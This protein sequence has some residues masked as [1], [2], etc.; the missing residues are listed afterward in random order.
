ME[1]TLIER[2]IE[3]AK[4]RQYKLSSDL[5]RNISEKH[6]TKAEKQREVAEV[7]VMALGRMLPKKPLEIEEREEPDFYYLAFL[8]PTCNEAVIGQ[9][10]RPNNCKHCGQALDWSE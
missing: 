4:H 8:C 9:P 5:E 3:S 1:K 6:R 2:A 7:T 10:Y